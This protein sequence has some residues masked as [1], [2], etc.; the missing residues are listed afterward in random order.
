MAYLQIKTFPKDLLARIDAA[1]KLLG[2]K[3]EDFAT[4]LLEDVMRDVEELEDKL[5]DERKRRLARKAE[6]ASRKI[7]S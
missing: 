6:K 5:R 7:T 3:K 1:A 2:I 4:E